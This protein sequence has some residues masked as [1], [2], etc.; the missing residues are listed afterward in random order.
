MK[1]ALTSRKGS[2]STPV[3]SVSFTPKHFIP[4]RIINLLGQSLKDCFNSSKTVSCYV[5]TNMYRNKHCLWLS[6][7]A[8]IH[9]LWNCFK[10]KYHMHTSRT[11]LKIFSQKLRSDN[12]NLLLITLILRSLVLGQ[13]H[14]LIT[15][16]NCCYVSLYALYHI[17]LD[18]YMKTP[19][20]KAGIYLKIRGF[21]YTQSCPNSFQEH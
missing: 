8:I 4:K 18:T 3:V 1:S 17:A 7:Y 16:H 20:C 10:R 12:S 5:H 2:R 11:T 19:S 13:I 9:A 21:Q 14:C 6:E 15:H